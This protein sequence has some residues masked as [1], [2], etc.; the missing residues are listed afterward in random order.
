MQ[1]FQGLSSEIPYERRWTKTTANFLT[2]QT[3]STKSAFSL[4]LNPNHCISSTA[5]TSAYAMLKHKGGL[6]A[7]HADKT[8]LSPHEH[9]PINC[10]LISILHLL[11]Y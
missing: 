5:L 9:H 11:A 10:R 8:M 2:L 1:F 7:E 3:H 4:D 6:Q